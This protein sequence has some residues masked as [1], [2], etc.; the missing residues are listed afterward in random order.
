MAR[1]GF[2]F[3]QRKCIGCNAC[4]MACKDYHDLEAGMFFRRVVTVKQEE[5]GRGQWVHYSGACNH[6]ADPACVKHCPTGAC[7]V[8]ADGTVG[9]HPEKCI[10][11]GTCTWACPYGAPRLSAHRGISMKCTSCP[12]RR[13]EGLAPVC[14]EACLTHC[15]SFVDLDSLTEQEKCGLTDRL[16]ILPS[17]DLTRPSLLIHR[18]E[19]ADV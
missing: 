8:R 12:E 5:G 18:K 1:L 13:A 17:P 16:P 9:H 14:V 3:D 4:Q 19:A 10:G 6:C 7:Y 15:L 11:C 2:V